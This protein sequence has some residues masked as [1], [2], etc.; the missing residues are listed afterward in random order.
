MNI[1][2]LAFALSYINIVCKMIDWGDY[3]CLNVYCI[4]ANVFGLYHLDF[5]DKN[6]QS[7][8]FCKNIYSRFCIFLT[9]E[10]LQNHGRCFLQYFNE[11]K[12]CFKILPKTMPI[13]PHHWS[14]ESIS[15]IY[16]HTR[17][18]VGSLLLKIFYISLS[19][20]ADQLCR[21]H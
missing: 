5:Y 7:I 11:Y 6:R 13:S 2:V 1:L 18:L 20:S 9:H 21:Q 16:L 12:K 14:P 3:S 8:F 15:N 10:N 19:Y 17:F 4:R